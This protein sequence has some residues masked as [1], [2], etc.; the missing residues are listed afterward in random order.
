MGCHRSLVDDGHVPWAAV[1]V[2]GFVDTPV[3]WATHEHDVSVASL[4]TRAGR[5]LTR[6]CLSIMVG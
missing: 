6:P 2:W 1:L 5:A 3:S 4:T